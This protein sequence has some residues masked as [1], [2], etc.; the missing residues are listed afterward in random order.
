MH[1][2]LLMLTLA[3]VFSVVAAVFFIAPNSASCPQPSARSVESLFAPCLTQQAAN[4]NPQ[5]A[6]R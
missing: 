5:Q 6:M 3:V 4:I 1:T 2:K